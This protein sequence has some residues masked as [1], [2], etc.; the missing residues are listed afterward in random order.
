MTAR[1]I[2][3]T[4]PLY[5]DLP[6]ENVLSGAAKAGL[7]EVFVIGRTTDGEYLASST[8]DKAELLWMVM[9]AQRALLEDDE[10]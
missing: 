7:E 9:R 10:E 6:V 1:V 5:G 8:G 2:D 4:G 3:F